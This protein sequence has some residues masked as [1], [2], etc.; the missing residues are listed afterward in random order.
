MSPEGRNVEPARGMHI[1]Y[2]L[3]GL[4]ETIRHNRSD[5]HEAGAAHIAALDAANSD[6]D[7]SNSS[8]STDPARAQ[9]V[10]AYSVW[11][12]LKRVTRDPIAVLDYQTARPERW[13]TFD[14]RS[15]GDKGDYL[16]EAYTID[17]PQKGEEGQQRWYY[18]SEQMPDEVLLIKFADSENELD[19]SISKGCGHGS[20]AIVGQEGDTRESIE[21]RVIAFW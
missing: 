1:D 6:S 16:L 9:R 12:P 2:S 3:Q 4:R 17:A 7:G 11:R 5:F 8:S 15:V 10:A 19:P 18:M 21:A 20:P 13:F 14:Y